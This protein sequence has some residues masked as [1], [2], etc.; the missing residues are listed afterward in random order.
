MVVYSMSLNYQKLLIDGAIIIGIYFLQLLVFRLLQIPPRQGRQKLNRA[1]GIMLM[2]LAYLNFGFYWFSLP[3][4]GWMII[5]LM[6]VGIQWHRS[7]ELVYRKYWAVFWQW[8]YVYAT[9]VFICSL[10]GT[11]LPVI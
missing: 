5:G 10:F 9:V 11:A 4:I 2:L 8:T 6:I 1:W 3:V 7:N